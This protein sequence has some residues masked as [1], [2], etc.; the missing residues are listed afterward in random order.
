MI[1]RTSLKDI[2]RKVGVSIALV[3]YVLNN[4]KEGRIGKEIAQKIRDAAAALNYRPNQIAKSLKTNKTHTIGLIVADI[5]NPFSSTLARIIED[6]ADKQGYTVIFGSSDENELKSGKLIDALLNR[7]VDGLII[8]PPAGSED[9]I[10]Q[11]QRQEVPFVLVD[12]YF[13]EIDT[14]RVILDNYSSTYEA[15]QHLVAGNCKKIGMITYDASLFHLQ[16]RKKG[17]LAGIAQSKINH[18]EDLLK[19]VNIRND[20]M[21]IETAIRELLS[22]HEPIDALLFSTNSLAISGLRYIRSLSIKVPEDLAIIG[23]DET[24]IFDF[25]YAP[26]SYI[27]QPLREMGQ[28]AINILLDDINKMKRTREVVMPAQLVIRKSTMK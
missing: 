16:Q 26:L 23:F 20:Q 15:V 7:Q 28:M 4:Q 9:Q 24:E 27:R 25:F 1:K 5:S 13:P 21:E 2:A 19:E 18:N 6:E 12:R 8:I 22:L 3:S 10:I 14:N 17:Y 11:L